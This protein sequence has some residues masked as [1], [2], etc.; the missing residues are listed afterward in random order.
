MKGI[1][2]GLFDSLDFTLSSAFKN[3]SFEKGLT[4]KENTYSS[5]NRCSL[6][7]NI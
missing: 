4:L 3:L 6:E 7:K 1:L 5:L 2:S